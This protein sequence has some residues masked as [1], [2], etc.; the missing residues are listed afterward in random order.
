[1]PVPI[2]FGTKEITNNIGEGDDKKRGKRN[3]W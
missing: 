2:K 3:Y 1:M